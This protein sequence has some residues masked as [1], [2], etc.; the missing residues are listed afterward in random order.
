MRRL[1][2]TLAVT[3][4]VCVFAFTTVRADHGNPFNGPH[5]DARLTGDQEVPAVDTRTHGRARVRFNRDCT[6][7]QVR[8]R[9]QNAERV[10]QAHL[11]CAPRGENGPVVAFIAGFHDA[12]WDV[13]GDFVTVILTDANVVNDACGPDLRGL[14]RAMKDGDVYLNV[15]TVGTPSGEVRGQFH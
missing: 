6:R 11:H 14:A 12:G 15:H 1:A 8:V 2:T 10:T 13:N 3:L 9:L 7:A 4:A 5:F